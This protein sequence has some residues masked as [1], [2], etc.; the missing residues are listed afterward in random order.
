MSMVTLNKGAGTVT[1]SYAAYR[2]VHHDSVMLHLLL[3]G[4]DFLLDDF[5]EMHGLG[6]GYTMCQSP[7]CDEDALKYVFGGNENA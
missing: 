3:S 5:K 7:M 6:K 4:N 2:T 1:M